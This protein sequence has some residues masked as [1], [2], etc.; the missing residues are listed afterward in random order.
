MRHNQG[1]F[2]CF[3]SIQKLRFLTEMTYKMASNITAVAIL[4]L[5]RHYRFS[6]LSYPATFVNA[7]LWRYHNSF[8]KFMISELRR[9]RMIRRLAK[10]S[11]FIQILTLMASKGP[12]IV[13]VSGV[14]LRRQ[15]MKRQLSGQLFVRKLLFLAWCFS[16]LHG[17][18]WNYSFIKFCLQ[19]I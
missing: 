7:F 16:L 14:L 11:W 8:V 13:N 19:N 1:L 6:H 2:F 10:G 3:G 12:K 18:I 15:L 9:F 5:V 17:L 4:R